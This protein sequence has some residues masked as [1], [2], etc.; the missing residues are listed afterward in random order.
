MCILAK[1]NW[2]PIIKERYKVSSQYQNGT[3]LKKEKAALADR[4]T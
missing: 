3:P 4:G 2:K 1:E